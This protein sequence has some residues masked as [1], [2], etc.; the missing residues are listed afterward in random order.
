MRVEV[1]GAPPTTPKK[2]PRAQEPATL[3]RNQ[4]SRRPPRYLADYHVGHM[5]MSPR[6]NGTPSAGENPGPWMQ[7]SPD[8][9]SNNPQTGPT[10][11]QLFRVILAKLG[12]N[13]PCP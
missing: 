8:S 13:T 7:N 2:P 9:R 10:V 1:G 5:K 12:G 3:E 11:T 4:R 6:R